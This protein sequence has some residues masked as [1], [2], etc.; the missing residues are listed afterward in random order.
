MDVADNFDWLQIPLR[1][2]CLPLQLLHFPT[3]DFRARALGPHR[4]DIFRLLAEHFSAQWKQKYKQGLSPALLS[5]RPSQRSGT[6]AQTTDIR[7]GSNIHNFPRWSGHPSPSGLAEVFIVWSWLLRHDFKNTDD[8]VRLWDSAFVT[9][10]RNGDVYVCV[11]VCVLQWEESWKRLLQD[12][13]IRGICPPSPA[14][15]GTGWIKGRMLR[16]FKKKKKEKK[17][18]KKTKI[19]ILWRCC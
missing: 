14:Q 6:S 13:I 18:V 15:T 7:L 5:R 12:E 9:M 10:G 3:S 4:D 8:K 16:P 19:K 17:T 2:G 1:I 11:C